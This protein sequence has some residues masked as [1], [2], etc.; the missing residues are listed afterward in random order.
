[1]IL[2]EVRV[3]APEA[4][5]ESNDD[6][7]V[8]FKILADN[9]K[10]STKRSADGET[11][12]EDS[13]DMR[14]GITRFVFEEGKVQVRSPLLEEDTEVDFPP[15]NLSDLGG[16]EGAPPR[17]IAQTVLRA[18]VNACI[19]AASRSGLER[20]IDEKLGGEVGEKAKEVLRG[21]LK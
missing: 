19:G 4:I 10:R 14:L 17:V 21:I 13:D 11:A 8:N 18:F 6:K 5:V 1:L 9:I 3:I 2:T 7:K 12:P 16:P 20:L 15:L